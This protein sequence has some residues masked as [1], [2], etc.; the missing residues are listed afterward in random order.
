MSEA[1]KKADEGARLSL[2][3][4]GR[5]YLMAS[6]DGTVQYANWDSID[7]AMACIPEWELTAPGKQNIMEILERWKA[8]YGGTGPVKLDSK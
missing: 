8:K 4:T 5:V 3:A 7:R 2:D 6:F 1:K